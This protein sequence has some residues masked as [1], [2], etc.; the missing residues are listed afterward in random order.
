MAGYPDEWKVPTRNRQHSNQPGGIAVPEQPMA[1]KFTPESPK[2]DH[3][4]LV[5]EELRKKPEVEVEMDY[6]VSNQPEV[7]S[8][9]APK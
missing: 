4:R 9:D 5:A 8:Y 2:S 7:K 1:R 3:M 6:E